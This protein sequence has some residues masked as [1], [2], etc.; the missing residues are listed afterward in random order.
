MEIQ[1]T[2]IEEIRSTLDLL[3]KDPKTQRRFPQKLWDS[4]I[5]LTN[6]YTLADICQ[7]LAI[8]PNFLRRKIQQSKG[9]MLEFREITLPSTNA[10]TIELSSAT[11]LKALIQGPISSL[12]CLYKL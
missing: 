12:D 3:R 7:E 1:L 5:Q 2:T 11:G 4:I 8:N 10:V 9:K 6:V